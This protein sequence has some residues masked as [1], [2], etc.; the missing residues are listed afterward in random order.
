MSF[1]TFYTLDMSDPTRY[2]RKTIDAEYFDWLFSMLAGTGLTV[3]YRANVAGRCYYNSRLSSP[4]DHASV[5]HENPDA[6]LWHRVADMMDVCD[7]LAEAV[8]AARKHNV[9]IWIWWN[10]NEWQNVRRDWIDL[11]DRVWYDKPRKYWCSRDGSRFYC[12]APDW[13]DAEVVERLLGLAQETLDYGVD[14]FYLSMRSH[15]WWPCWP[16]PGWDSNPEPFGFNDSVVNTY[17]KR[18]GIDIRY[19]DYDED[20]WL[21]IKGEQFS[22]MLMRVGAKVHAAD[23]H[24]IMGTEP[25]RYSLMVDFATMPNTKSFGPCLK[26]YKDWEGWVAE[27]SIDGLCAE[28]SCPPELKIEGGDIA[29]FRETLPSEF[30]LYTWIDTARWIN[31]G[32]GPFSLLNWDP[33]TPDDVIKQLEF[34]R[35]AGAAG[36]MIHT[37]YHFTACD[38]DGE[39]MGGYGVLPR[40]EYLEAIRKWNAVAG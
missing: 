25:D 8:R 35:N 27:G 23:K 19:E 29:P 24:F 3:L 14:G 17:K 15:S 21:R 20:K 4:F 16:S 5:N 30:P 22:N 38:S 33:H 32:G 40:T 11:N 31:R 18:Y 28:E 7:P 9:P 6:H 1:E 10:W 37:M 26:L 34:G 13:G 36:V 2:H 39:T 12:G